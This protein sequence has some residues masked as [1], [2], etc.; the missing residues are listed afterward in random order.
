MKKMMI[1]LLGLVAGLF[2]QG[3]FAIDLDG[4]EVPVCTGG[5]QDV[6]EVVTTAVDCKASSGLT[7]NLK[8]GW[9]NWDSG[10]ALIVKNGK[11]VHDGKSIGFSHSGDTVYVKSFWDQEDWQAKKVESARWYSEIKMSRLNLYTLKNTTNV[12]LSY[13]VAGYSITNTPW[14]NKT[15]AKGCRFV[16]GSSVKSVPMICTP[17]TKKVTVSKCTKWSDD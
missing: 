6:E 16:L 14:C 10:S 4:F 12:V 13:R 1:G 7:I 15:I 8:R 17:K 11:N 5:Y 2:S 3:V 9:F